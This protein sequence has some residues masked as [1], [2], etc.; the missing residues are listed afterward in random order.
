[1]SEQEKELIEEIIELRRVI[2]AG[3]VMLGAQM[4]QTRNESATPDPVSEVF[5]QMQ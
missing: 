1:M 5:L 3:F 2:H 4:V